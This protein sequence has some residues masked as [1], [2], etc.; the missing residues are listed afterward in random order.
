MIS[1]GKYGFKG[2]P[3]VIMYGTGG[4]TDAFI[5]SRMFSFSQVKAGKTDQIAERIWSSLEVFVD[6][7]V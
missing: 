5:L 6:V 7:A 4:F 1:G 2:D 3:F